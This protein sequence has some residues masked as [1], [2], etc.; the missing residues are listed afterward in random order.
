CLEIALAL[1]DR[2]GTE[3]DRRFCL[4]DDPFVD[5]EV[6]SLTTDHFA[7]VPDFYPD[8]SSDV[9]PAPQKFTLEGDRVETLEQSKPK[10]V[11]DLVECSNDRLGQALLD[12]FTARHGRMV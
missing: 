9:M 2:H 11:V 8:L 10:N 7:L 3:I 5:N 4:D 6:E 1:P 12:E